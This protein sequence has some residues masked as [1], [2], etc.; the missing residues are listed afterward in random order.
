MKWLTP[1]KPGK[2][3]CP[4][5][6]LFQCSLIRSDAAAAGHKT[7]QRRRRGRLKWL[8]SAAIRVRLTM[9]LTHIRKRGRGLVSACDLSV[10]AV[11]ESCLFSCGVH[12]ASASIPTFPFGW[13]APLRTLWGAILG[14]GR[15]RSDVWARTR[16]NV[17]SAAGQHYRYRCL[18][19]ASELCGVNYILLKVDIHFCYSQ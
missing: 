14:E 4:A 9:S 13:V 8:I 19:I 18:F 6:A 12:V 16:T 1:V 2:N 7:T 15:S 3:G 10:S 17:R 11:N 5:S